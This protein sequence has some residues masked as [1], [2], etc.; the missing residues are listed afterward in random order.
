M[1]EGASS[2][3]GGRSFQAGSATRFGSLRRLQGS[4]AVSKSPVRPQVRVAK[5]QRR[6]QKSGEQ[7]AEYVGY[8]R[9]MADKAFP[10]WSTDQRLELVRDQFI[11]GVQSSSTQLRLM[12]KTVEE[13]VTL[14]TQLEAI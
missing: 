1:D 10:K 12:P 13:A 7:Q 9:M 3:V 4:D 6:V 14:A 11:Q 2:I 8:L 5:F